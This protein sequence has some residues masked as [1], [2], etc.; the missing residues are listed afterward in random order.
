MTMRSI[1]GWAIAA[2]ALAAVAVPKVAATAAPTAAPEYRWKMSLRADLD[3]QP[4]DSPGVAAVSGEWRSRIVAIR[5]D[6][7]DVRLQL[8]SVQLAGN[9]GGAVDARALKLAQERL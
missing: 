6:E 1:R 8:A 5:T 2:A 4:G 3:G 7:Y 9:R